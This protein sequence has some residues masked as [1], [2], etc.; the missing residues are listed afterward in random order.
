MKNIRYQSF[1]LAITLAFG[2]SVAIAGN[3]GKVAKEAEKLEKRVQKDAS[4]NLISQDDA[5]KY[6]QQLDHIVRAMT[7][8]SSTASERNGMR[9]EL[10]RIV[11]D[12]DAAEQHAP[13]GVAPTQ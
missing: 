1:I 2:S 8:Q 7:E 13:G 3:S 9:A 11:M 10:N 5:T 6:S 12:L 4:A